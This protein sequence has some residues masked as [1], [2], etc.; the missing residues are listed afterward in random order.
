MTAAHPSPAA[1][2][3]ALDTLAARLRYARELRGLGS[4]ELSGKCGLSPAAVSWIETRPEYDA[5]LSTLRVL[6]EILG[7]SPGWLAFG[8]GPPPG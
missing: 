1:A 6:A 5:R 7:V 4:R 2:P 3:P 8:D